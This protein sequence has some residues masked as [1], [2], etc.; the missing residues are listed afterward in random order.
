MRM[1]LGKSATSFSESDL[2]RFRFIYL[3]I[4]IY[5]GNLY[6]FAVPVLHH[7]SRSST[8]VGNLPNG[9]PIRFG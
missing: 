2:K 6:I 3:A 5:I 4:F 7:P 9:K 8:W 1:N